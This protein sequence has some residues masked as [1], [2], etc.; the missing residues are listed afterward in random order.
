MAISERTSHVVLPT[1]WQVTKSSYAMMHLAKAV[2]GYAI[3]K[4][5][6]Y[7]RLSK[8]QFYDSVIQSYRNNFA[9]EL[10]TTNKEDSSFN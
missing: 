9:Q 2:F 8:S 10:H 3:R 7:P 5:D 1:K 6:D 4:K